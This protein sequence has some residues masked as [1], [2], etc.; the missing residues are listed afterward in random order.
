MPGKFDR[1]NEIASFQRTFKLLVEKMECKESDGVACSSCS[2]D[3]ITR[4]G[5]ATTSDSEWSVV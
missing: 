5:R 3:F 2:S 4:P 1:S